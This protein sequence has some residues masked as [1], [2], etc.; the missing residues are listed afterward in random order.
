MTSEK[1]YPFLLG[2]FAVV[3]V[4]ILAIGQFF[5]PNGNY[6]SEVV[7]LYYFSTIKNAM[8]VEEASLVAEKDI[9]NQD[10]VDELINLLYKGPTSKQLQ[11]IRQVDV[12]TQL[13]NN[14]VS[15]NFDKIYETLEVT[16]QM[17]IRASFVYTL[18]NLPFV[19]GVEF[20]VNNVALTNK[21]GALIGI[22]DRE[23]IGISAL[24]PNPPTNSQLVTLYFKRKNSDELAPE[25]REIK[26]NKDVPLEEYIIEE[27]VKGPTSA[28]LETTFPSDI[29]ILDIKTLENVTQVDFTS[30]MQFPELSTAEGEK[31]FVY[32]IVNSL[33]ELSKIQQVSFLVG[34]EKQSNSLGTID[35]NLLFERNETLIA[36]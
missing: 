24:N 6:G 19:N 30:N 15:V 22:M 32:S 2:I 27:L 17:M 16:E 9:S 28:D 20:F 14:V 1:R 33:T 3:V 18:T 31:L 35:F 26:V 21:N 13:E 34:G 5:V 23:N 25:V 7:Q 36:R 8:V 10:K 4:G 29:T 11:G 12:V